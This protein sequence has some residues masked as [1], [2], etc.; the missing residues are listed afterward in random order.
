MPAET[1]APAVE[2]NT[3]NDTNETT[4]AARLAANR[5]NAQHSTGAKTP[6]GKSASSL[7]ALKTGLTGVTVILPADDAVKYAAHIRAYEQEFQPVGPEECALVQSIADTRWRL[8]RIPALEQSLVLLCQQD[9]CLKNDEPFTLAPEQ[10]L[11]FEMAVRRLNAKEFRNL[12]LQEARLCRRREKE[13]A[14]LRQIQQ[15]RKAREAAAL[16]E[17]AKTFLLARQRN[18]SVPSHSTVNGFEFSKERIA[19]YL[20]RADAT[21]RAA[22]LETAQQEAT[23]TLEM[24]A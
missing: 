11:L 22:L 19:S 10:A 12:A 3:T 9:E 16:E 5:A 24:A 1:T 18:Q 14:E 17:A 6:E 2:P 23:N 20:S 13:M 21:K 7:N 15:E 8:N 4:S